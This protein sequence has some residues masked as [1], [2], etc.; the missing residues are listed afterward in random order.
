MRTTNSKS[1]QLRGNKIK[2]QLV[3]LTIAMN[4]ASVIMTIIFFVI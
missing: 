1:A 3:R 4:I 2:R